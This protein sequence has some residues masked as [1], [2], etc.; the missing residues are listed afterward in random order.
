MSTQFRVELPED[1]AT[2]LQGLAMLRATTPEALL[3][4]AAQALLADAAAL[5]AWI[6]EGEAD[7][8]AGRTVP[9]EQVMAELDAII[10][11]AEA[12]KA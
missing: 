8:A 9:F 3:T 1:Q 6:A 5:E 7:A 12:A 10:A 11:R 4:E 2:Q